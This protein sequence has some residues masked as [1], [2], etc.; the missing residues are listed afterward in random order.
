MYPENPEG[1]QVIVCFM[2]MGYDINPTLPGIDLTTSSRQLWRTIIILYAFC[3]HDAYLIL[4]SHLTFPKTGIFEGINIPD[5]DGWPS[6]SRS[7][8]WYLFLATVQYLVILLLI[9][10][11]RIHVF[12]LYIRYLEWRWTEFVL[13]TFGLNLIKIVFNWKSWLS[14]NFAM[15]RSIRCSAVQQGPYYLS[16]EY[17]K[18]PGTG[19]FSAN[20]QVLFRWP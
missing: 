18:Q 12:I 15:S 9:Y 16:L 6:M 13:N 8:I 4:V 11:I 17:S 3:I 20:K 5:S 10:S 14:S 7:M 1:N 19:M 2:N